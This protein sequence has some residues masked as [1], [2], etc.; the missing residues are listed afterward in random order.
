MHPKLTETL[1]KY[2]TIILVGGGTG[3]HIQPI[4]SL[5]S[6]FANE[7]STRN[8]ETE[9]F[10]LEKIPPTPLYKGGIPAFLWIG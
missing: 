1:S 2:N 4:V 3:G 10:A 7:L 9:D 8:E 6:S 5:V